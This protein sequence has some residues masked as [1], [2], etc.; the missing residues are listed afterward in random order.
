M[1]TKLRPPPPTFATQPIDTVDVDS[2]LLF[3]LSRHATGEPYFGKRA[4]NRFDDPQRAFGTCYAALDLETA[5]AETVLHG[6]APVAGRFKVEGDDLQSRRL[7]RFPTGGILRMAD[8][9]GIALMRM[10]GDGTMSTMQPYDLPQQWSA[11][12]HDHPLLVDGLVYMSRHLNDRRAVVIFERAKSKL[13][14]ASNK[15]L[16]PP[17]TVEALRRAFNIDYGLG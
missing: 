9:T 2:R 6:L 15:R 10:A 14:K 4:T 13:G 17:S 5:V 3:R 11:A 7:V 1:A 16:G 12:A 8:F